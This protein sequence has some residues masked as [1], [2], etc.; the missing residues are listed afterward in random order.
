MIKKVSVDQLR[1]G[2]Y[3]SDFNAVG[4]AREVFHNNVTI[5]NKRMILK[6]VEHGIKEVVIDTSKGLDVLAKAA[7]KPVE[8]TEQSGGGTAT[9]VRVEPVKKV[10]EEIEP[11]PESVSVSK[12]EE[13]AVEEEE[14]ELPEEKI[15]LSQEIQ[16]AKEIKNAA[17]GAIHSV[18]DDVLMGNDI[19]TEPVEHVVHN[20]VESVFRNRD[21]LMSLGVI[22][23]TDQYTYSHS[24][25]VCIVMISFF[26][27]LGYEE[28][29]VKEI[30]MGALLHDIGKSMVPPDI[31]NK[32][33]RLSDE[34]F[35]LI[36]EHVNHSVSML[37]ETPGITQNI[38]DMTAQHHERIDGSGYP[39][40]LKGDEICFNAQVLG[41]ADVYD[42]LTSDRCYKHKIHPTVALGKLF[43]WSKTQFNQ[44]LVSQFIRC[45][46]V[47]PVGSVVNLQSGLIG[48]VLRQ[49]R[50]FMHP[51]VRIIYNGVKQYY[52]MSYDIDLSN[53]KE[54][55]DDD[56]IISLE[57][58]EKW[59]IRP[60]MYL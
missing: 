27:T 36:K 45:V 21:A 54:N 22:R 46:G 28:E 58:P 26:R 33:G 19:E 15:S 12:V 11:R 49:T 29:Q 55:R 4:E 13:V 40:R 30:G 38:L 57:P 8:S 34:E 52:V 60:E 47:Y 31:L 35:G 41:I 1:P 16:A 48:I 9:R 59:N 53:K 10:E 32:Q 44:E 37:K 2:M 3:I 25:S 17:K 51:V 20:M 23:R 7:P 50:N 42:A 14:E 24:V 39:N 43:E 18:M 6:M 5:R 56:K